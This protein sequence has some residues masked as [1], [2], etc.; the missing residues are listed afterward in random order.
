[1]FFLIYK[2]IVQVFAFFLLVITIKAQKLSAIVFIS[3]NSQIPEKNYIIA[4]LEDFELWKRNYFIKVVLRLT[5][6]LRASP[7]SILL[8]SSARSI[9]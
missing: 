2:K 3:I 4:H 9:N 1:M 6:L 8:A 7:F 5:N